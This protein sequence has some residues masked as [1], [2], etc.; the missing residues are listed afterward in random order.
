LSKET[1]Q[2]LYQAVLDRVDGGVASQVAACKP[3]GTGLNCS[4]TCYVTCNNSV[5]RC[6]A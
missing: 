1:L 4:W 2:W 3:G 5:E 6:C